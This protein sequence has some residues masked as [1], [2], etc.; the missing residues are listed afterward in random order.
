MEYQNNLK[1][2]CM[3]YFVQFFLVFSLFFL[4]FADKSLLKGNNLKRRGSSISGKGHSQFYEMNA[5]TKIEKLKASGAA[6]EKLVKIDLSGCGLD[7]DAFPIDEILRHKDTLEFL[8][9]GGNNLSTLPDSIAELKQLRILFFANNAF[10]SI[11]EVLGKLEHLYMLSFKS[12]K[13]KSISEVALSP[14]IE[15]LILT[16]N[17]LTCLPKSIGKLLGLRKCMLAGN[18]ITCLPEEMS[19][20]RKLELIRILARTGNFQV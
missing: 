9:L 2:Y 3:H 10:E 6:G 19:A 1:I 20:C 13:L 11:P 17:S 18:K 8:N 12:C 4:F 15:W 16:D 7:D 5:S 14:S